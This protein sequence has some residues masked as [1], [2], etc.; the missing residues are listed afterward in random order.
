MLYMFKTFVSIL[1]GHASYI[2]SKVLADRLWGPSVSFKCV[3]HS[4]S[5]NKLQGWEAA[6]YCPTDVEVMNDRSS[7]STPS[8]AFT[9]CT[10]TT[11]HLLLHASK[12]TR[13]AAR[14]THYSTC[15][16]SKVSQINFSTAKFGK[17]K[18]RRKP[19]AVFCYCGIICRRRSSAR[20]QT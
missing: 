2:V 14:P 15:E 12:D 16:G 9:T 3:G 7:T 20:I 1:S 6:S 17:Q 13:K 5:G 19:K 18:F 11:L 10:G 4:S 8:F